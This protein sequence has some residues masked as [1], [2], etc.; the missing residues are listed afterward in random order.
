V[1]FAQANTQTKNCKRAFTFS[2]QEKIE[3]KK[4]PSLLK[5][6][7]TQTHWRHLKRQLHTDI[8]TIERP[9]IHGLGGLMASL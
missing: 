1:Q 8:E 7:N 3:F 2:T 9:A 6:K 4:N 5:I